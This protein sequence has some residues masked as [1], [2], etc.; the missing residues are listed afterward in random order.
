MEQ[1]NVSA[2]GQGGGRQCG[3][4]NI[5]MPKQ[6][7]VTHEANRQ[8]RRDYQVDID[9]KNTFNA[10]LQAAL[11]RMMDMF[12]IPDVD[13]LEHIYNN[14]TVRLAPNDAKSATITF[15]TGVAQKKH[16][17]PASIHYLLQYPLA[18]AHSN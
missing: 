4:S 9:F 10:T 6:H 12:H 3:C 2:P 16:F 14:T 18:D 17:V 11:R 5:N 1:A 15:D 7:F 8:G 13:S